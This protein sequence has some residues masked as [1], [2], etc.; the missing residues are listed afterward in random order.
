MRRYS[1]SSAIMKI[2]IK[3]VVRYCHTLIRRAKIKTAITASAGEDVE[4]SHSW[5]N[6]RRYRH[7]GKSFL[8]TPN[9]PLRYGPAAVFLGIYPREMKT[10]VP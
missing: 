6:R 5:W 1:A 3:A 8:K 7:P 4:K 10:D 2:Q 9:I